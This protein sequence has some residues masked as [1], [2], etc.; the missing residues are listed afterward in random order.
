MLLLVRVMFFDSFPYAHFVLPYRHHTETC[1]HLRKND[2]QVLKR[3][4]INTVRSFF[5]FLSLLECL[6]C[7]QGE[8]GHGKK[9]ND[10]K[11]SQNMYSYSIIFIMTEVSYFS[12]CMMR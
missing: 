8:K 12:V 5:F 4:S 1:F 6:K 7:Y 11:E 2:R 3:D 10:K 9:N